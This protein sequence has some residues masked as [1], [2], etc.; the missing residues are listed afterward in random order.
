MALTRKMLA[1][2]DIP[3]EK[4]DEII[5]AHRET[6]DAIKEECDKAKA[7]TEELKKQ[8]EDVEKIQKEL[9]KAQE[10]LAELKD[11]G[12]DWEKKYNDVKAEYDNFKKD[13]DAKATKAAKEKAYRKLLADAGISDKRIDSVIKVSGSNI[14]ELKL[15]KDGNIEE[16]D[17]ITESVKKEWADFITTTGQRGADVS[18]PPANNGN[19]NTGGK[20]SRAAELAAKFNSEHYGNSNSTK[21]E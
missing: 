15:D 14:D 21:E 20:I 6:V 10:E 5:N 8:S 7:E 9:K 19:G 16:A 4:V 12:S 13:T 1:A 18:N 2:M 17:K 3:A 11:N